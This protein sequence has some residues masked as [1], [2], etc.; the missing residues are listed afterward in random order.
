MPKNINFITIVI[1]LE[2]TEKI[3]LKKIGKQNNLENISFTNAVRKRATN[4]VMASRF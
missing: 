3:K 4:T 1:T 2:G